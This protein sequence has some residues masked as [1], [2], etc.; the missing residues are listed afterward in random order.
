[1]LTVC[2]DAKQDTCTSLNT[3]TDT[4]KKWVED[5]S[6]QCMIHNARINEAKNEL[7][8]QNVT[9]KR[10]ML[11]RLYNGVICNGIGVSQH[12]LYE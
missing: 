9:P 8:K 5:R 3:T 12:V 2:V 6:L 1:M 7:E 10:G 4:K 11:C